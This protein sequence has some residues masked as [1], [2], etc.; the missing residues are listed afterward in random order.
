MCTFIYIY[1]LRSGMPPLSFMIKYK[2]SN[3]EGGGDL[4]SSH[5]DCVCYPPPPPSSS[6]LNSVF[7]YIPPSRNGDCYAGM[8][9]VEKVLL[10]CPM[11]K[12]AHMRRIRLMLALG[13]NDEGVRVVDN[14]KKLF[15]EEEEFSTK[16][17]LELEKAGSLESECD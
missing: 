3:L 2:L 15:P 13:W 8:R 1:W 14:F 7:M 6:P 9:D 10:L 5:S 16:M 4:C 11:H 12:K 17:R